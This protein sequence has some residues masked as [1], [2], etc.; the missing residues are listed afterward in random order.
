MERTA[1]SVAGR[2]AVHEGDKVGG[3]VENLAVLNLD[4]GAEGM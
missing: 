1:H 3:S 4:S 2:S